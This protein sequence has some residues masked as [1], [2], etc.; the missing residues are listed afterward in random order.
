M[1]KK[2]NL[3]LAN[4]VARLFGAPKTN[5]APETKVVITPTPVEPP[6][7]KTEVKPEYSCLALGL[8][9]SLETEPEKW[10]M[11]QD[12]N[13]C[14]SF[15]Y[16]HGG[17]ISYIITTFSNNVHVYY[18]NHGLENDDKNLLAKKLLFL[19]DAENKKVRAAQKEIQD[20]KEKYFKNLGCPK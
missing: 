1:C 20:K 4:W 3:K 10:V 5:K 8:V 7:I 13:G 2:C 6:V 15:E 12:F 14:Y 19:I 18:E 11:R 9:K 17:R 16:A